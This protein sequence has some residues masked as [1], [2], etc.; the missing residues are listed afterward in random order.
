MPAPALRSLERKLIAVLG[1]AALIFSLVAGS[2]DY[3]HTYNSELQRSRASLDSM[4]GT[5]NS[6]AA[7]AA[8]VGN[9]TIADDVAEGLLKSEEILGI[10][11]R[12]GRGFHFRQ[13][14]IVSSQEWPESA[15]LSYVLYSPTLPDEN[16]GQLRIL[17]H[18]DLIDTRARAAALSQLLFLIGQTVLLAVILAFAYRKLVGLPLLRLTQELT[19]IVPGTD[20]RIPLSEADRDNEIGLVVDSVNRYLEISEHALQTERELLAR[21]QRLEGHYRRIFESA[22][23]GI[24]VL[25]MNGALINCNAAVSSRAGVGMS[26]DPTPQPDDYLNRIFKHPQK[27]WGLI[28]QARGSGHVASGDLELL[29][30]DD[31]ARWAHGLF[32]IGNFPE[33]DLHYIEIVFYDVT[34]RRMREEKALR[35]A[36]RDALTDLVNRRGTVTYLEQSLRDAKLAGK[37]ITLLFLDLDGFKQTNDVYGH[38]AGDTV[39][40][41]VARRLRSV[42]KR[43][44]DLLARV[45]GD[46]FILAAYGMHKTD[47]SAHQLAQAILEAIRAPI[48]LDKG[49]TATIGVS[50]GIAGYPENADNV[51]SLIE[52]ADQAM[53]AAKKRG[54]NNYQVASSKV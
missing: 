53:Y 45:G 36:E 8:Y 50:I 20:Q 18:A 24:M 47:D 49:H 9:V 25:D 1:M 34:S 38:A 43:S 48:Q 31:E 51:D 39:L 6:S 46:E 12:G 4:A 35:S 37:S 19:R 42:R 16:I 11:I 22:K 54:K 10:E 26:P 5:V 40:I 21:V 32:S 28:E 2:T 27:A 41:E 15:M 7:I 30:E 44:S 33:E 17:T 3:L 23:V 52:V 13:A 14:K 29:S